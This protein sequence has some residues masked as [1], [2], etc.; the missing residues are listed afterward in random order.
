[1]LFVSCSDASVAE[2]LSPGEHLVTMRAWLP[3]TGLVLTAE[4]R[5]SLACP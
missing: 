4:R 3:G 5:V 1:L 2:P